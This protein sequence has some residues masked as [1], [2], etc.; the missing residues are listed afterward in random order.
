LSLPVRLARF[1]LPLAAIALTL[2]FFY[3]LAFTDLILARGDTFAYFYPYWDARDTA[4]IAGRLPLWSPELFMGVPLLA[5]SQLG[6]LYPPNW[7]TIPLDAP[8]AVRVSILLHSA[9][10]TLGAALLA[11]RTLRLEL[12]PA[13]LAGAVYG[14]GGHVGAHVEQINQLHG[15]A[16]LPWLFLAYDLTLENP[17]RYGLLLALAWGLQLLSGH[18]Q[19]AFITG[20]G[21]GVYALVCAARMTDRPWPGR[22][23]RALLPLAVAAGLALL[24]A[25]PQLI[26]T[27]ELISVSNRGGG[28][29]PQQATA[30]SLNPYLAGRGLLPSYDGQPFGEYVA[31]IGVIG[32]ALAV[33]GAAGGDRRRW[34]WLALVLIGLLFALGR[35]TPVYWWLAHLPGFNLF[36]VPARWLA[37]AA[38]GAALLAGLGAQM[39]LSGWHKPGGRTL[40][41]AAGVVIGLALAA[42]LSGQA[43]DEV[44][45]PAIPTIVTF[46]GWGLAL[47]A[48]LTLMRLRPASRWI[49]ALALLELWA[50]GRFLPHGD[51]S[52]PDVYADRRFAVSQMLVY[53]DDARADDQPPGRLLSISNLVFDPGDRPALEARWARMGLSERA[54]RY[55]FTGTKMQEVLAPNLP[56]TWGLPTVDGFDGG[57]LPTMHYTAF[58]ALL[59]PEGALRTVDGRLRE[60]LALPECR[61]ACIPARRWL[62]LTHTRYLLLDKVYDLTRDGIF[63]DTTFDIALAAGETLTLENPTAFE[64]G[65]LHA[66]LVPSDG[67]CSRAGCLTVTLRDAAGGEVTPLPVDDDDENEL[68]GLRL[69]RWSLTEDAVSV[70]ATIELTAL[71]PARLR[72]LSLVDARTGD[73]VQ[74]TAPGWHRLYS[75]DIKIYENDEVLPRAFVVHEAVAF[76]DSWDGTEDAL[77]F[78][79]RAEFD[80]ARTVVLNGE[81]PALAAPATLPESVARFVEY[82]PTRV[83]IEVHA[84]ADGYLLLTDAY[85]PGWRARSA[86]GEQDY[87]LY[88]A[89]VM[90]RAVPVTAGEQVIVFEYD[91]FWLPWGL[92]LGGGVWL[93]AALAAV[94]RLVKP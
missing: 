80:P 81:A 8:E 94:W 53:A 73:F 76:P 50:A 14:L 26:P 58:S 9:W 70:P 11:R 39:L 63:Y 27:Q 92:V 66:L 64:A 13:L 29:T 40:L 91:P 83:V 33:A 77:A 35:H 55:A 49:L 23:V 47:L 48:G 88:R 19:T 74:L 31:Y 18:T 57:I 32:L 46:A 43:A 3:R 4:L 12:L 30:F 78:M 60:L 25:L 38:L 67:S 62:N 17:R 52:D 7:L 6:T 42:L 72:G 21:L 71:E 68:D 87:P 5:N 90:F 44:D 79:R 10:A 85:Y 1:W 89:A 22:I 86:D 20:V 84:G 45:G 16:W 61:G 34:P 36:R 2:L 75:A 65:T 82:T 59:L 69:A 56:L 15:L 54:A 37:L 24:L 41:A 93:L 51:L 28:L